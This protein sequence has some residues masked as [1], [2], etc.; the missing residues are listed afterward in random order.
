MHAP[1]QLSKVDFDYN[2]EGSGGE[3][4][5]VNCNSY[6]SAV[7]SIEHL[8]FELRVQRTKIICLRT[9]RLNMTHLYHSYIA[10]TAIS[11]AT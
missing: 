7:M 5:N 4:N 10:A 6:H 2:W 3:F 8:S 11:M 1:T 9:D